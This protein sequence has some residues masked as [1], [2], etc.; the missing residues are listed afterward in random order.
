MAYC[1]RHPAV[2]TNL[3]CNKCGDPICPRCLVQTPV[4]ARCPACANLRKLPTY[5]FSGKYYLRGALAGIL[6]AVAIGLIWLVIRMLVPFS[7]YFNFILAG[8]AG[9]AI[10]EVISWA[11]NRRRG[12][13]LAVMGGVIAAGA[14]VIS[15]LGIIFSLFSLISLAVCIVVAVLR[16]R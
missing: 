6:T 14:Y 4:G 13:W 3:Y 12:V 1:K 15:S 7:G 11:S 5:Q 16:L 10:G 8:A 9:Y 2:E